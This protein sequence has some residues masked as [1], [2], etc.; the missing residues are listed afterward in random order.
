MVAVKD[1]GPISPVNGYLV[2]WVWRLSQ[3]HS[4][5]LGFGVKSL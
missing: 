4:S 2:R 1:G 3:S 5:D